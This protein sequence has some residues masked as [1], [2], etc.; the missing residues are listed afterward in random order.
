MFVVERQIS[1]TPLFVEASVPAVF[2][3]PKKTRKVEHSFIAIVH[4]NEKGDL[5]ITFMRVIAPLVITIVN[6]KDIVPID[7]V[8]PVNIEEREMKFTWLK[9]KVD[10]AFFWTCVLGGALA[11]AHLPD[12]VGHYVTY[13]SAL[14]NEVNSQKQ[15][16]L[17][18]AN[19]RVKKNNVK[20]D[21]D[22]KIAQIQALEILRDHYK[23]YVED[24]SVSGL[25]DIVNKVIIKNRIW[26]SHALLLYGSLAGGK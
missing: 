24:S 21:L 22:P 16:F 19:I 2:A 11:F 1:C 3:I 12:F 18:L 4:E 7:K 10:S 15:D 5:I 9:G 13:V 8:A 6:S 14:I 20:L 25:A 17:A 26:S 23:S